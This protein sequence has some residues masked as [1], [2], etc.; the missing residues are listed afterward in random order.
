[1]PYLVKGS[2]LLATGGGLPVR[3]HSQ[4]FTD[5]LQHNSRIPVKS[6]GDFS[7]RD[8]LASIYG[9]GNP[10]QIRG[11]ISSLI[12]DT[13]SLFNQYYGLTVAGF[14]PGEIGA[15]GMAFFAAAATGLPVVDSDLV[16]GRA[17]PEMQ[18]DV[19]SV[20][21]RSIV[22]MIGNSDAG[23]HLVLNGKFSAAEVEMVM[24]SFF[25]MKARMGIV[26]GYSISASDYLSIGA[27]DTISRS[28]NLGRILSGSRTSILN[29][30]LSLL[31]D[32]RVLVEEKLT[33]VSLKNLGGFLQGELVFET[34]RVIIKNENL[35]CLKGKKSLARV[36]DLIMLIDASTFEPLHNTEV[37]NFIGRRIIIITCVSEKY[38]Y[39]GA[40]LALFRASFTK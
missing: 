15:E 40:G 18:M 22:P 5:A 32:A 35:A 13:I 25:T 39:T 8:I 3:Q 1:M 28:I 36:P 17:A 19:F 7:S 4:L 29:S 30:L 31:K 21:G 37:N 12:T 34:I 33:D 10:A 14:I 38:W 27:K 2:C 26:L 16:G 24:R 11:D 6:I 23:R 20:Y 9:V